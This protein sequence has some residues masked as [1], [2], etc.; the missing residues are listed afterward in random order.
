MIPEILQENVRR[1]GE[2]FIGRASVLVGLILKPNK[3]PKKL[4][5]ICNEGRQVSGRYNVNSTSSPKRDSL[6]SPLLQYSNVRMRANGSSQGLKA[7][8]KEQGKE[9]AACLVPLL[10]E[11]GHD[12]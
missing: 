2:M 5:T 4:K 6:Y 3:A 7:E 8:N 12:R 10:R 9:E 11:Y 1:G